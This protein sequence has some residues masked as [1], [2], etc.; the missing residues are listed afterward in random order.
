L[1]RLFNEAGPWILWLNAGDGMSLMT[2]GVVAAAA[3]V[4]TQAQADVRYR[5]APLESPNNDYLYIR[6]FNNAGQILGWSNGNNFLSTPDGYQLFT[7]GLSIQRGRLNTQF[8]N[9]KGQ[10]AFTYTNQAGVKPYLYSNGKSIDLTPDGPA[11]PAGGSTYIGNLNERGQVV[12]VYEGKIFFLT[13]RKAI[14]WI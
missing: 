12:G 5:V 3:L 1:V 9:D 7:G 8:L 13:A 14:I 6:D 10:V 11:N 2:H 4:T